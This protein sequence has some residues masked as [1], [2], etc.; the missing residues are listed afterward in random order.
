M[1]TVHGRLS[2]PVRSAH[3]L[4]RIACD[5][6]THVSTHVL[7]ELLSRAEGRPRDFVALCRQMLGP[8]G[9]VLPLREHI[10]EV[11]PTSLPIVVLVDCRED[12]RHEGLVPAHADAERCGDELCPR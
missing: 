9:R 4:Y 6:V 10:G 3:R 11:L 12:G 5:E 1:V 8:Q 2:V 7:L